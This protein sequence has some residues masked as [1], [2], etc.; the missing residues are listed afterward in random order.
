MSPIKHRDR[1][2]GRMG[3]HVLLTLDQGRKGYSA[4]MFERGRLK[5]FDYRWTYLEREKPAKDH[6]TLNSH[7]SLVLC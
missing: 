5:F 3:K 7:L 1:C 2:E 6:Y 4:F